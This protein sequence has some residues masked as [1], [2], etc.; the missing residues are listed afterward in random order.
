M[1]Q[2]FAIYLQT[3]RTNLVSLKASKVEDNSEMGGHSPRRD[4]KQRM[5]ALHPTI[6]DGNYLQS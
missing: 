4:L 2:L 1:V 3:I 6:R 5:L